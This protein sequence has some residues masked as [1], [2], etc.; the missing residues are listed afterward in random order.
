MAAECAVGAATSAT[1]VHPPRLVHREVVEQI[2]SLFLQHETVKRAHREAIGHHKAVVIHEA[3]KPLPVLSAEGDL[4]RSSNLAENSNLAADNLACA[5]THSNL[6]LVTEESLDADVH[7]TAKEDTATKCAGGESCV[8]DAA[9]RIITDDAVQNHIVVVGSCPTVSAVVSLNTQAPTDDGKLLK[10]PEVV[11][12]AGGAEPLLFA[13]RRSLI[14]KCLRGLM[15][16]RWL[17]RTVCQ[18]CFPNTWQ[19]AFPMY[20]KGSPISR[21]AFEES[22]TDKVAGGTETETAMAVVAAEDMAGAPAQDA[23]GVAMKDDNSC[24]VSLQIQ[25]GSEAAIPE[26]TGGGSEEKSGVTDVAGGAPS[27]WRCS[28][29]SR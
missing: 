18:L 24:K 14:M 19:K 5:D 11:D 12:A 29:R 23:S 6:N 3:D 17:V 8:S 21:W 26:V 13:S 1:T 15:C 25:A 27:L 28:P 9:E 20:S 2:E 10:E 7:N 16:W 22:K 4:D